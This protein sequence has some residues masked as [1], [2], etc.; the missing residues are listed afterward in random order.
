MPQSFLRRYNPSNVSFNGILQTLYNE[1][2]VSISYSGAIFE[3]DYA[4]PE[5]IFYD[6]QSFFASETNC[7]PESNYYAL[8]F[9][10]Y[11]LYVEGYILQSHYEDDEWYLRSWR[12]DGSMNGYSWEE[13]HSE[14]ETDDLSNGNNITES[15]EKGPFQHIRITQTGFSA[16]TT[17]TQKCRLRIAR[18]E[19]FGT[20][21]TVKKRVGC[22]KIKIPRGIAMTFLYILCRS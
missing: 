22:K 6:N 19:L 4:F 13:L 8:S 1:S 5:A 9:P 15:I 14:S 12:V 20:A 11:A 17:N 16:G 21:I 2:Q 18:L 7:E 3:G 10:N